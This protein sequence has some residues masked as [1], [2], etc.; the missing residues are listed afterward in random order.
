VTATTGAQADHRELLLQAY[1]AYNRQDVAALV[2]L[3]SDDVDWPDD[4]AGRL[5]G[6]DEVRAYWTEQWARTRTHD[7]PVGFSERNDG[8]T[9]VHISQ[10]VR[11]LDGPAI[12]KGQFLH[13]HRIEGGR[14]VRMDIEAT[15][16]GLSCSQVI[17]PER[18]PLVTGDADGGAC[19]R[20]T[21]TL[22]A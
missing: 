6:K 21:T 17:K 12:S 9:A 3:I 8:R 5:H 22:T 2:A 20:A 18:S 19:P 4:D 7:E 13:L 15:S 1:A 14:I 11:S 16:P 10:V